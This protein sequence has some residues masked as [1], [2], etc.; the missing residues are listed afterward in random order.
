MP[1]FSRALLASVLFATLSGCVSQNYTDTRQETQDV[2][3]EITAYRPSA[4]LDN[5]ISIERPPIDLTPIKQHVV[6]KWLDKQTAFNV[7]RLPLGTVL[8]DMLLNEK[9]KINFLDEAT[10][11]LIVSVNVDGSRQAVLNQLTNQT[12]YRFTPSTDTLNIQ[13]FVSETFVINLP[14]G[15][16]SGQLGSQGTGGGEDKKI[17]GQFI[18]VK[19]DNINVF[20]DLASAIKILLKAPEDENGDTDEDKLIGNVNAISALSSITVRTTPERMVSVQQLVE[21]HQAQLN[22]QVLLD[23]R[24]LEFRSNLDKDQGIDW[25]LIKD[26]GSGSLK[27]MIPGSNITAPNANYG[28]AF[29]ATGSWDG[30][31]AFIKAL[32]QQGSVSTQTPISFL[33]LNSQ[34]ARISQITETPYLSDITTQITDTSTNTTTTRDKVTEGIDMMISANVKDEFV[35]L[36]LAGKLSKIAG[37]SEEKIGDA[38]LRFIKMRSVD[39]NFTNKLRYGQTVVIGSIK[40]Q[41]TIANKSASFGLDG[42]GSQATRHET[43]ETLVL[44]TPRSV[45]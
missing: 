35:W 34:P 37:E 11:N 40:Q 28:L 18:N 14:S 6:I 20:Q 9:V 42:L 7:T 10:P 17:E 4:L 24:I 19:Y 33:A 16:Y 39:M 38:T 21:S 12:G 41:T 26:F 29:E 5:V 2:Q 1:L 43:V 31:Q 25:T 27:F 8:Q 23:I 13:R 36:R 22:K 44:L 15:E 3:A 32:E 30:T 45:Q